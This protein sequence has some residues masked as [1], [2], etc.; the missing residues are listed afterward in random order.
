MLILLLDYQVVKI[1]VAIDA[2]RSESCVVVE[3]IDASDLINVTFA[4]VVLGAVLRVKVVNPDC[5][6]AHC[7]GKQV[8]SIREFYF[9]AGLDLKGAWL[10]RELLS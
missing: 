8:A 1:D 3:P 10:G 4:L 2:A 9:S 5:V 6:V 7:T